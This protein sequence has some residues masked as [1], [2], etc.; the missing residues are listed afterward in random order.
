M[1]GSGLSSHTDRAAPGPA[2]GL[3]GYTCKDMPDK[4]LPRGDRIFQEKKIED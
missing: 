3:T 2:T 1:S 4:G